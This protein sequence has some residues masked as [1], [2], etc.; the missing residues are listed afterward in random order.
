VTLE[1]CADCGVLLDTTVQSNWRLVSGWV[2]AR[3]GGGT[4]AL[5]LQSAPT[6]WMCPACM[7]VRKYGAAQDSKLGLFDD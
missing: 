4:H 1:P 6:A 2:Q 7:A 3:K 5:S